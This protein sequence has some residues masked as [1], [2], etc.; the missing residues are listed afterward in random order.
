MA[1]EK[2]TS[3]QIML[4]VLQDG[5]ERVTK[6]VEGVNERLIRLEVSLGQL[7]AMGERQDK[8]EAKLEELD[9]DFENL[10]A[11]QLQVN[12]A[13]NLVKAAITGGIVSLLALI[14]I[15]LKGVG[16]IP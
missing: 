4:S 10:K 12:G 6:A 9:T 14:A 13:L 11:W 16:V 1:A 3:D 8:V 15:G 2:L 7:K 5:L